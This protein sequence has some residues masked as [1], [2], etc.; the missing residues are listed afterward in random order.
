MGMFFTYCL[1]SYAPDVD[2]T[3][4]S[5]GTNVAAKPAVKKAS[6]TQVKDGPNIVKVEGEI[7][8]S[9]CC[10]LQI[11]LEKGFCFPLL[12]CLLFWVLN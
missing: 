2:S 5:G 3:V 8:T 9:F 4:R 10:R 11:L 7:H 12:S 6:N 1:I